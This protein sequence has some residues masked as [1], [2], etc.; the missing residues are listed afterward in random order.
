MAKSPYVKSN[1]PR[2]PDNEQWA[3]NNPPSKAFAETTPLAICRAALLA[4]ME[5]E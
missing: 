3:D 1:Y 2:V 4:V 5:A